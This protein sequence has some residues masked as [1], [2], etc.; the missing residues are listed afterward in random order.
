MCRSMV[1]IATNRTPIVGSLVRQCADVLHNVLLAL[2]RMSK[3]GQQELGPL[4]MNENQIR[5]HPGD[6]HVNRGHSKLW[7][8]T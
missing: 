2:D 5:L 8:S 7:I 6:S 1:S 3:T 4:P